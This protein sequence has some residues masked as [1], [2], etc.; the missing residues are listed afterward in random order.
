MGLRGGLFYFVGI[1]G[2]HAGSCIAKQS[3]GA[4]REEVGMQGRFTRYLIIA[5]TTVA[6]LLNA[7][8]PIHARRVGAETHRERSGPG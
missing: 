3:A 5:A 7:L 1:F 8:R 6:A 2:G 4:L